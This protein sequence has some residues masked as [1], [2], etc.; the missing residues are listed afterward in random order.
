MLTKTTIGAKL[1]GGAAAMLLLAAIQGYSSLH[2][3]GIF[4]ERFDR[5]V[6]VT[7]RKVVLADQL[8]TTSAAM[9]SAQRGVVLAAFT[10]H[11]SEIDKY[12]QA[13][14]QASELVR[15]SL[16]EARPL[17]VKEEA[18]AKASEIEAA[19]SEWRP[20][21][22]EVVRQSKAGHAAEADR[23][24][25]D[26]TLPIYNRIGPAAEGLRTIQTEILAA[27]KASVDAENATSRQIALVLLGLCV[28]VAGAFVAITRG[29][30]RD[31]RRA[32]MHLSEGAGQVA[33]AA[34]Q[35]SSASQSLAQ[36]SSEQAA[37]LE[38]TSSSSEEINSMA[39]KNAE[40]SRVAAEFTT[41]VD[42]RVAAANATLDQMVASMT[43]INTSSE[44]VSKIIKVIDEI[45]FQT[46]ILA[47]NAAVE[48]ARAGE[49][50]M[51]FA[52]VADEVRNLAQ[53]CAQAAKDTASLIEESMAKSH[54]GMARLDQVAGATRSI[55]ESAAKVKTLVDEVHLGSQEQARG[56][57]QIAKAIVQME[58]VTQKTAAN[59]E[60]SA[61]ASEELSAQAETMRAVVAEL[62]AL[63]GGGE[64]A[65]G[66]GVAGMPGSKTAS[67]VVQAASLAALRS[68][69]TPKAATAAA[70]KTLVATG[71]LDRSALP[72][73][74]EFT[75]F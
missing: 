71:A 47:L 29:I 31:L 58:Q 3:A 46:N 30:T 61:S 35:I 27:E 37:S 53:R 51:G 2:T 1:M 15:K 5:A 44:K 68:A 67:P 73:D 4:R 12:E 34:T 39:R 8:A 36:G 43:D 72:L 66:R 54:D 60:E 49:A 65:G 17:F 14:Q 74:G 48:A 42:E 24:R 75:E 11:P 9:I 63:V 26:V 28:V 52:V 38:E 7:V 41:Q 69:V 32:A 10:K 22:E 57:E 33:S 40:N 6:D 50:G 55:T 23:I 25:T 21:F 64:P 59:A 18:K 20:H 62:Q 16:A 56:I 19:V 13:Y 70:R 45:A